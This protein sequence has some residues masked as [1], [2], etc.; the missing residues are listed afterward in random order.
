MAA[1]SLDQR[2]KIAR[3]PWWER[4]LGWLLVSPTILLLVAFAFA[5]TYYSVRYAL[6]KVNLKRGHLE[7]RWIKWDNFERALH[8]DLVH[9]SVRTTLQWTVVVTLA[10]VFLGLMLALLMTQNIRWRSGII[11]ILIIPIILPP[12]SVAI[13]W[14][15][16][17]NL[18]SGIISYATDSLGLGTV[19]W[20]NDSRGVF[21]AMGIGSAVSWLPGSIENFINVPVALLSMMVV[22]IWQA[23]PFT[24]L[25]LYA[26]LTALPRDPYEAA[27][28]DG[29]STWFTFKTLTLPMLR[30]VLLVVV[31]LRLIDSAR[32]FDKIFLMTNGGPGTTGYTMTLTAYV[33]AFV[34]L[35]L[36]YAAALSF[37][38]QFLM[39]IV[40][41]IYV[42]RVLS[43]YSAPAA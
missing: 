30:P 34:K 8:D 39:I 20:L 37:M 24:F 17:Y 33:S 36:G 25:L 21:D 7:L 15:Y 4:N 29:A 1:S 18:Q 31:L 27:S 19:G 43:D 9:Q 32:I 38:F 2:I 26:G 3:A 11:S 13:A 22:D 28:I 42:K 14:R 35:D 16:M 6:S 12:V 5:P 41:T 10:E 40:G 23:T